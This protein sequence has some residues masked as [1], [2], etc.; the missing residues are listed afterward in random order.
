MVATPFSS[1]RVSWRKI[2]QRIRSSHG[3]SSPALSMATS[4]CVTGNANAPSLTWP[5][6]RIRKYCSQN[7]CAMR[8]VRRCAADVQQPFACNGHLL[9]LGVPHRVSDAGLSVIIATMSARRMRA[10]WSA[11]AANAIGGLVCARHC[12]R[13]PSNLRQPAVPDNLALAWVVAERATETFKDDNPRHRRGSFS[14][15]IS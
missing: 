11:Q 1:V 8:F 6:V 4:R 12:P 15:Q 5:I 9:A 13:H 2:F 10:K 7:G 3:H 14:P